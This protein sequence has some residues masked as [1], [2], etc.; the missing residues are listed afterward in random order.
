MKSIAKVVLV[1][2]AASLVGTA[3]DAARW[4]RPGLWAMSTTMQMGMGGAPAITAAQAAQMKKL[5]IK[6]PVMG[7]QTIETK[8]CVTPPDAENFGS[9]RY[10]SQDS[11][12][13]Q[14]S[15]V[16]KGNH[17]IAT[18]VCDGRMKGK[19]TSDVTL[20]DDANYTSVFTFKGVSHGR[21]VDM[22]VSA[23]AHWLGADCGKVKPFVVPKRQG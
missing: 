16:R 22:K 17:L 23:T 1:L 21:P 14:A 5:G 11:G 4:G 12:C 8:T 20:I 7:G 9:H 3:A 10:A 15:V 18:V 2:A 13:S 6:I 19:G